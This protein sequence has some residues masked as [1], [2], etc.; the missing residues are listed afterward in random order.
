MPCLNK[1]WNDEGIK[2]KFLMS[3]HTTASDEALAITAIGKKF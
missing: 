2:V 3:A 1:K